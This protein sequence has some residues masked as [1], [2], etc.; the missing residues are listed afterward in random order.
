MH[1]PGYTA[2]LKCDVW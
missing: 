1:V 2:Q